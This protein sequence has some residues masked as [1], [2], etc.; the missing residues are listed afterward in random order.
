MGLSHAAMAGL[1][2]PDMSLLLVEPSFKARLALRTSI[3]LGVKFTPKASKE[4]IKSATH[5]VIATPPNFHQTNFQQL[6][7]AEFMGRILIEK[8]ISV[9]RSTLT[10]VQEVMSGYI[11]RHA[12]FWGRIRAD[13]LGK[14]IR[15]VKIRLETNQDFDIQAEGWRVQE[16]V[17]GLSLLFEFGSHC[18]NLLLDL[19]KVDE[20]SVSEANV[21]RIHLVSSGNETHNIEIQANSAN[22]RKSVYTVSIETDSS[23]YITDFYSYTEIKPDGSIAQSTSLAKEGVNATAYLRGQEFTKQMSLFLEDAPLN[24]KDIDD[25]V[26]TD[27]LLANLAENIKCLK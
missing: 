12:Y 10:G 3:G 23:N 24:R 14:K 6:S 26:K 2:E 22:V 15:K 9:D 5:A 11:L 21:N 4:E 7:D 19:T 27:F 18:V 17:P 20:L 25:A 1:L 8:P 16:R 13:T